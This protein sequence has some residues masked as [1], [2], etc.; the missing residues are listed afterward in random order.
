[1]ERGGQRKWR[2]LLGKL[3]Y[4][5]MAEGPWGVLECLISRGLAV[6]SISDGYGRNGQK[7]LNLG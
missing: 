7:T 5:H 3:A 4:G 1:M 2:S 6:P